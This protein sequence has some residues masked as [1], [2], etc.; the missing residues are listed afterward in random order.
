VSYV[1][2]FAWDGTPAQYIK[3]I[4]KRQSWGEIAQAIKQMGFDPETF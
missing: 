1:S 3:L 2:D 4:K